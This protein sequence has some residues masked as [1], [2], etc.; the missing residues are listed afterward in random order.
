[1]EVSRDKGR[2][3]PGKTTKL[4]A[5][6]KKKKRAFDEAIAEAQQGYPLGPYTGAQSLLWG[7]KM[8]KRSPL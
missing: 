4:S 6:K 8:K 3:T 5:K 7:K 2:K 1:M